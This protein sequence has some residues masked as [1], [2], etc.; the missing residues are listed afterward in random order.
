MLHTLI[1][2]TTFISS[3][4]LDLT[5]QEVSARFEAE[6]VDGRWAADCPDLVEELEVELYGDLHTL[7][8]LKDPLDRDVLLVAARAHFPPLADLGLRRLA[9][10]TNDA[11]REAVLVAIEHPSPGVRQAARILLESADSQLAQAYTR[12]WRSGNR[13]GWN[14]LVPDVVPMPDQIG[15]RDLADLRYRYFASDEHRA[16]FTS[17]LPPDQLLQRIAPGTKTTSGRQVAALAEK[18]RKAQE[19]KEAAGNVLEEGLARSG[20]GAL[21]GFAKRASKP[22]EKDAADEKSGRAFEPVA[23]FPGDA[24]AVLYALVETGRPGGTVRVA[25]GRDGG[26]GETVLVVTY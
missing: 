6:C 9:R 17:G 16:V 26:I 3:T 8:R 14:A 13:S 4:G 24:D 11:D 25:A 19:N 15:L 10:I 7:A 5:P 2:L 12:W 1:A 20:L 18:R 23:E 21:A 22:A